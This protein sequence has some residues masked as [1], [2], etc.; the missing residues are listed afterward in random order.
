MQDTNTETSSARARLPLRSFPCAWDSELH[1]SREWCATQLI[2]RRHTHLSCR[3]ESLKV[4]SSPPR[5][6]LPYYT[7]FSPISLHS[8]CSMFIIFISLSL[9][10]LFLQLIL[11]PPPCISCSVSLLSFFTP[12]PLLLCTRNTHRTAPC[13][14]KTSAG[15]TPPR[16][17]TV[18]F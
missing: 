13:S 11:S 15:G 2:A 3:S 1:V 5:Y 7:S 16:S 12:L 9:V 6:L 17:L 18:G 8:S 14:T 10:S 4:I